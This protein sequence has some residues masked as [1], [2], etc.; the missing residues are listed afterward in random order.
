[1]NRLSLRNKWLKFKSSGG[2]PIIFGEFMEY[3]LKLIKK[4]ERSQHVL[5]WTWIQLGFWPIMPKNLSDSAYAATGW[6]LTWWVTS[7]DMP[8]HESHGSAQKKVG[9]NMTTLSHHKTLPGTQRQRV[10]MEFHYFIMR[11]PQKLP[12]KIISD[13][14]HFEKVH[15]IFGHETHPKHVTCAIGFRVIWNQSFR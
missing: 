11:Y 8:S 2:L 5:G 15:K 13:T 12:P 14:S 1:M 7:H 4:T 10:Q 9:C 3:Y 6:Y